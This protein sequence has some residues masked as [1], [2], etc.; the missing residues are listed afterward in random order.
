MENKTSKI[1]IETK[2][3][4]RLEVAIELSKT[5]NILATMLSNME[6]SISNINLNGLRVQTAQGETA[7]QIGNNVRNTMVAN[8]VFTTVY[9]EVKYSDEED[10]NDYGYDECLDDEE[11]TSYPYGIK[12]EEEY[13]AFVRNDLMVTKEN[14]EE[15][16][17]EKQLEKKQKE[18]DKLTAA[19]EV[20]NK[21]N[22]KY[23]KL[24]ESLKNVLEEE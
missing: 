24:E 23:E 3:D 12:T 21:R 14:D 19:F 11:E 22:M 15:E 7:I 17:L 2:E 9:D 5:V 18:I 6:T 8:S 1:L 16:S 4:K 10:D 13:E 20:L